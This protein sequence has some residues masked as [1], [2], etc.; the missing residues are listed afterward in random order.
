M[1]FL[2]LSDAE[3]DNP[4]FKFLFIFNKLKIFLCLNEIKTQLEYLAVSFTSFIS[5]FFDK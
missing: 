4:T 3:K 1:I 5:N 2:I